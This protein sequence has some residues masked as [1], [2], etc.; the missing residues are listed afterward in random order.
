MPDLLTVFSKRWE[1]ILTITIAAVLLTTVALLFV[2]DRYLATVTA[3]PAN[4]VTVDKARFFNNNIQALYSEIGTPD[5]LDR[6]VGSGKLDTIYKA[7]AK[8]INLE[9]YYHSGNITNAAAKLKENT[10]ITKSE[11][12]ELKIRVWDKDAN[13]AAAAANA[14]FNAL[15]QIHR[16]IQTQ[17]FALFVQKLQ[18]DYAQKQK[19]YIQTA[20][21]LKKV[22]GP[23]ADVLNAKKAAQLEQLQQYD[24][25]ISEYQL[26]INTNAPA[27]MLVEPARHSARPDEPKRGL[28]IALVF[29]AAL[30]FSF[31]LS[32]FIETRS[33]RG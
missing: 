7:A 19:D 31:L 25:L 20:D 11:Y 12:G 16:T 1:T 23:I 15:Q 3:L 21:S 2:P 18:A 4:S 6:I 17:N 29:F 24:K 33:T 22:S 27:L 10:K 28:T 8:E 30:I 9:N 26:M 13:I 32:L 14:L 5:D